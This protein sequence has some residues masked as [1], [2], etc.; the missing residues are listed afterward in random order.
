MTWEKTMNVVFK[1]G[2]LNVMASSLL[3]TGCGSGSSESADTLDGTDTTDSS[4]STAVASSYNIVDTGQV[5]C[6]D[7]DGAAIVCPAAS[8]TTTMFGWFARS[9]SR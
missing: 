7:N 5:G 6:Y 4:T 8:V 3:L 2:L 9:N 1:L